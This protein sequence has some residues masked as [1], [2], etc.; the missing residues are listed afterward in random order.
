MN[1]TRLEGGIPIAKWMRRPESSWT[2]L[3]EAHRE[4]FSPATWE[5]IEIE[6]KYEGYLKRQHEMVERTAKLEHKAIPAWLDY[7]EV[8]GLKREAQHKL[9]QIKPQTL[10][11]A[12]RVSGITPADIALLAVWIERGG[13]ATATA[14]DDAGEKVG[15]E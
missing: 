10:G 12:G 4:K 15:A 5:L 8:S 3:D 1:G 14:K 7:H 9:D 6:A 11:Q 2:E 13:R